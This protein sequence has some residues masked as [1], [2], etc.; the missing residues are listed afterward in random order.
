MPACEPQVQFP[1]MAHA[2]GAGRVSSWRLAREAASSAHIKPEFT[3]FLLFA[4]YEPKMFQVTPTHNMFLL[5][6]GRL[7]R[8]Y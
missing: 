7:L 5:L 3:E 8:L 1:V 6:N 4:S 2:W